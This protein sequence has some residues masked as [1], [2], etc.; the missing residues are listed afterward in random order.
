V[1][2][3]PTVER[4]VLGRPAR[5]T[6]AVAA[7]LGA[8]ALLAAAAVAHASRTLEAKQE[9]LLPRDASTIVVLDLSLSIPPVVYERMRALI[10]RL[11][12]EDASVGLVV[13]SDSAYE[14]LPPGTPAR[15][16]RPLLR[17][18]TEQ[19][20]PPDAF[21]DRPYFLPDPWSDTFRSGTQISAA[22]DLARELIERE[23]V[24]ATV[25]LVS[26]LHSGEPEPSTLVIALQRLLGTGANVRVVPLFPI[27]AN[28]QIFLDV[29]G[30]EAF[31][32]WQQLVARSPRSSEP[33][34]TKAASPLP[35]VLGGLALLL[36]LAANEL[37]CRRL[38][39]PQ[40]REAV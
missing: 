35:L 36:A 9:G 19:P 40:P 23:R 3:F 10:D 8:A 21:D 12:R 11:S 39:V 2:A 32:G 5:R 33:M 17:F 22:I 7:A 25:L 26:D 20:R 18:L 29:V 4:A 16:L 6:A 38:D 1:R 34:E 31:A 27:E 28:K 30:P 24:P 37:W 14:L 15:E 13:F